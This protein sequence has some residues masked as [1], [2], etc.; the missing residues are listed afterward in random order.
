MADEIGKL[1]KNED[2]SSQIKP[3]AS[4]KKLR[5][6]KKRLNGICRSLLID[7]EAYEPKRTVNSVDAYIASTEKVDRILYSVISGFI[8]GLDEKSR[9]VFSTNVDKLLQYVLD[10]ENQASE[11]TRKICVKLYD[12]FQ[13]NL[14]QIESASVITKAGIAAA[15][16]DE[17]EES[18]K[19]I[20]GIQKEYI[21]ILGIFAA[22]MLAFVGAFTFST[23]VLNNLGK[24][25]TLELV[26]VAIVIGLVFVLLISILIDFLRDINDK[27]VC[28]KDGKKKWNKKV[29]SEIALLT[30]IAV[31]TMICIGISRMSFPQQINIG[32]HRYQLVEESTED[33]ANKLDVDCP[34][35]QEE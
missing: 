27:V 6:S 12:H 11:D 3:A 9:G 17:V 19:E 8:V 13:L 20:K 35:K 14:I 22:I 16:K 25:D 5:E 30:L 31:V 29:V 23:S 4:Q 24:A 18:H 34:E 21:T 15:M 32:Q 28:D 10:E 1:L 2:S 33:S 26:A 7:T